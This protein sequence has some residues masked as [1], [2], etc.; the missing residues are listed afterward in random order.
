MTHVLVAFDGSEQAEAALDH[1][2]A[3]FPEDDLTVL[4]V[5]DPAEAG[6]ATT[7]PVPSATGEWYEASLEEADLI[8]EEARERAG[9]RA[10]E[11]D[12]V[13]GRPGHVIVEYAEEHDVDHIVTGSHGRK[14]VARLLLG[15]VA[16]TVVRRSPVPVTVVR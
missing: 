5:I 12:T 9:D 7:E 6:Y 10:I 8:L 1:A 16:E 13:V 11:T 3:E 14:G 2:L 15:S 4:T